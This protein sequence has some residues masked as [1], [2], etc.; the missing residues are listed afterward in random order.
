MK[1]KLIIVSVFLI[2][3]VAATAFLNYQTDDELYFGTEDYIDVPEG[4]DYTNGVVTVDDSM[5]LSEGDVIAETPE[6]HLDAG[7]YYLDIDHQSETDL[8]VVISDGNEE[9]QRA[10]LPKDALNTRVDFITESNLY[11]LKISYLY[12]GQGRATIKRSILY[13]SSGAFFSDTLIYALFISFAIVILSVVLIKTEFFNAPLKT[14]LFVSFIVLYLIFI[15]YMYYRPFPLEAEDTR[16]HLARIEATYNEMRRGQFPIVLYSDFVQGRGM[17]GIMYPY[18]FLFIPAF[19]RLIRMSPEGALRLFFIFISYATC[20]TSYIAAKKIMKSRYTAA[21]TMMLYGMLIY[22]ITTMTY[23]YAYGELQAFIFFPLVIWGLYEILIGD[24]KKWLILS[25]GMTGLLQCHLLSFLQAVFLCIVFG[26]LFLAGLFRE[27]RIYQVLE[28]VLAT[29]L[30]NLWYIVPFLTYY[31]EDLGVHDHLSWGKDIYGFSY[32]LTEMLRFFPNTTEGETQHKMG[33]IGIW[34]VILIGIAVYLQIRQEKR[35]NTSKFATSL[36]LSGVVCIFMASK[37]FPWMTAMKFEQVSKSFEYLQFVGRFYMMGEILVLFGGMITLARHWKSANYQRRIVFILVALVIVAAVQAYSVSDSWLSKNADPFVEV[38]RYRYT[39]GIDDTE[40]EDYVPEGY[41]FGEGVEDSPLSPKAEISGY[42]H[43]NLHTS[44]AY[45]SDE[46]TYVDI[47]VLYYKGYVAEDD[48]G[49]AL[50]IEKGD[51][52]CIRVVLPA[53]E[54]ETLV[55]VDFSGY[56]MWK[57]MGVI[58]FISA[59]LILALYIAENRRICHKQKYV[60]N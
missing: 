25:L 13:S 48:K 43:D 7:G 22:R 5:G 36:L 49:N 27:K 9:I 26:I 1:R 51:N 28:A 33:L 40:V 39:P 37:T 30:I 10:L 2:L 17:I 38:S 34:L 59:G 8:Q 52:G 23:R 3:F 44:F 4:A 32:Y 18:L 31:R 55:R 50:M 21:A 47:P 46:P 24:Q 14:K 60:C 12:S 42:K 20:A 58:S 29:I 11:N 57:C 54:T 45:N 35:D 56:S 53:C 16:Y 19:F 6:I 41:W 15:N